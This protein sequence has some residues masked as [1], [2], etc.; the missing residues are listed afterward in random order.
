[1]S[2]ALPAVTNFI[3]EAEVFAPGEG[4]CADC[5]KVKKL[6]GS[7]CH[8]CKRKRKT[9]RILAGG[10]TAYSRRVQEQFAALVAK[11]N[12]DN[13]DVPSL[14]L[15]MSKVLAGLGGV[16]AM[17]A[18]W[19]QGIKDAKSGSKTQLDALSGIA[20][21]CMRAGEQ[22]AVISRSSCWICS[23][24]SSSTTGSRS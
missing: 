24:T 23:P 1:M 6:D 5:R 8:L 19:V 10:E 12:E 2:E 21:F 20:K 3:P 16:D 18:M 15:V 14:S 13:P 4:R 17:A 11:L 7:L 9:Q 22:N